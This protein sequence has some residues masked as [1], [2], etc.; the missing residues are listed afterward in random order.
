MKLISYSHQ[1]SDAFGVVVDDRII[2]VQTVLPGV[3]TL[4]D[5][6][7][8]GRLGELADAA[9]GAEPGP[10]LS[11]V[12]LRPP[13]LAPS[14]ILAAGVNYAAHRA[15]TGH[16]ERPEYPTFFTRF[17]DGHVAHDAA[18][19]HPSASKQLDYEGE[20]A[21]VIGTDA[22]QITSDDAAYQAI[23]GYALFNDLSLRDWQM[24]SS[25]WLPGK[26]FVGVGSFGPYLV[27]PDELGPLNEIELTTRVNGDVR[28]HASLSELIFDFAELIKYVTA[29]T[30]LH[31]GDL[32]ITGT[33]SGIGLFMSPPQFLVP[34]DVVEVEATGLG[35]LRNTITDS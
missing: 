16:D 3:T 13:I 27:T 15:E 21:I 4:D 12:T 29:F 1:G 10:A 28:Q 34:G 30:P 14:K 24:H 23:A 35:I 9:R 11:E 8:S 20:I 5:V 22:Y 7:R 32:I 17:P 19:V 25:Q 31:A 26:N 6:L 18:V 2:N 33:P